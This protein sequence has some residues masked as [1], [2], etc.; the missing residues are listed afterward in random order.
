M[1]EK[2]QDNLEEDKKFQEQKEEVQKE[3]KGFWVYWGKRV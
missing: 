3:F 2:K 1:E